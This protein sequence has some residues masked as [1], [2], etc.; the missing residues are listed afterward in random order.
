LASCAPRAGTDDAWRCGYARARSRERAGAGRGDALLTD[1]YL[2][3]AIA[4]TLW[5]SIGGLAL[6]RRPDELVGPFRRVGLLVRIAVFDLLV[7]PPAAW[8]VAEILAIPDAFAIGLILVGITSAGPLSV[9]AVQLARGDTILALATVTWLELANA[10]VVPAWATI[11]LPRTTTVPMGPVAFVLIAGVLL[12]VVAGLLVRM[13]APGLADRL[14]PLARA[15]S[16]AG[17]VTVMVIVVVGNVS[18]VGEAAAAGVPLATVLLIAFA[19]AGG[20]LVGGPHPAS[21]FAVALVSA[22][23]GSSVALA[24]AVTV[25]PDVPEAAVAVVVFGMISIVVVPTLGVLARG[26]ISDRVPVVAA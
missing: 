5:G 1:G 20:W 18:V 4:I 25:F 22:Q 11:L 2:T 10:L 9:V 14:V 21:R 15:V 19:L 6:V 17:L 7:I 16:I 3:I 12:P 23:R 26:R 24:I 8:L 13:H